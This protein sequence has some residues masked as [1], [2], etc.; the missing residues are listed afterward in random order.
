MDLFVVNRYEGDDGEDPQVSES[1]HDHLSE[2]LKK[3]ELRK[4][5]KSEVSTAPAVTP[6]E[7]PKKKKKRKKSTPITDEIPPQSL[8]SE[9]SAITEKDTPG[10]SEE[11]TK[12]KPRETDNFTILGATSKQKRQAV[13]RVLPNWLAHPEIISADLSTGPEVEELR[14]KLDDRLIDLLKTKGVSRFFP[15]QSSLINWMLKCSEDR[16]KGFWPRDTC[17]SAPTGSGKTLAYVL[18]VI[19]QLRNRFIQRISCLVVV[20]VQELALQVYK[21][22]E[23]YVSTTNL[24]VGLVSG[25]SSFEAEQQSLV[26][27]TLKGDLVSRVDIIVATPGRLVDHIEQT[28]GFSL[29]FLEFLVIDEADRAT[30]W[31]RH[32]PMPHRCPPPLTIRNYL[33]CEIP[34][35]QKL[36]FSAT[37]SQDPEKLSRLG[38]FQPILFTSVVITD[39]DDD[40]DLDKETGEFVGKYTSPNELMERAVECAPEYKPV[41]LVKLITSRQPIEKTLVF[42]NSGE[43]SHRL[44]VLLRLML[45][46]KNVVVDELSAKLLPRQRTQMLERFTQDK[47]QIL[48]SSDALARGVDIAGV[49]LVVSY[50]LPKHIKGYIHRAGRTGRAGLPGTAISI[51]TSN[52]VPVFSR[53]LRAAHKALPPIEQ[54][55]SLESVAEAMNYQVHVEKLKEFIEN[56]RTK[57]TQR[58]KAKRKR[59]HKN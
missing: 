14:G 50:D 8:P 30:D 17:V 9:S 41:A 20:P 42:T 13:K 12:E 48:V 29:K 7:P 21:V 52:Q 31:L 16:K 43:A 15:V 27:R 25:A 35:A 47:S 2:L 49:K 28:E 45:L 1:A 4:R 19:Q 58:I 40:V 33:A 22:F 11:H 37:L 57:E 46:D 34:P 55:E 5:Q 38:L 44:A 3:I 24:G 23:T 6:G 36:L 59:A 51:L 39:R 54:I 56:E 32:I 26:E 10:I 53:M 18:P